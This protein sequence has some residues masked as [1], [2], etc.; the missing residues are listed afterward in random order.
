M[1]QSKTDS[2]NDKPMLLLILKVSYLLDP[3]HFRK[4]IFFTDEKAGTW[5]D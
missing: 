3:L 1:W 5:G 2:K 4:K